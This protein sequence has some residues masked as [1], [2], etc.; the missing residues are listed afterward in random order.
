MPP[1]HAPKHATRVRYPCQH[2]GTPKKTREEQCPSCYKNDDDDKLCEED[3]N[4]T[5]NGP[6]LRAR[7]HA[8]VFSYIILLILISRFIRLRFFSPG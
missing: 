2:C 7:F 6:L 5:G 3:I 8:V 4:R 1:K